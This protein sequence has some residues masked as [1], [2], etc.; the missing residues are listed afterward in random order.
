MVSLK[1]ID[2]MYNSETNSI[3]SYFVESEEL[4]G[5]TDDSMFEVT[6]TDSGKS[7]PM[8]LAEC[9]QHFGVQEFDEIRLG[10]LPHI[11]C[12]EL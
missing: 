7:Y 12:I 4:G 5:L 6:F 10:F 2:I 1:G 3:D 8:T 11:V 9:Q